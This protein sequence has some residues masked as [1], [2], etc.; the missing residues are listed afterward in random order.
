M[1]TG[2]SNPELLTLRFKKHKTTILLLV[3]RQESFTSVKAR[4][5]DAIKSTGVTQIS[6]QPLPQN[7]DD[8]I[9]GVPID[10]NDPNRG[11][12]DLEIPDIEDDGGKK[13]KKQSV[14][15]ATPLGAGLKDGMVLAFK[16]RQQS[17]KDDGMDIDD[18]EW[19]V[20]MP[21][22]DDDEGSQANGGEK[23]D[24]PAEDSEDA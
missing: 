14:L 13:A 21:A 8:I 2:T 22:F 7:A 17:A 4:L 19:D 20:V 6:G 11:W 18:N 1:A 5:Q 9:L 12:I 23:G 15:N 24:A 3:S 16:F 10:N